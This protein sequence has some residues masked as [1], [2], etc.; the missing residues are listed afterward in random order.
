M[1][2]TT[3]T[4]DETSDPNEA[5]GPS[6]DETTEAQPSWEDTTDKYST[7]GQQALTAAEGLAQGYAGPVATAAELVASKLGVPGVS[8]EEISARQEA[9]PTI[10]TVSQIAGTGV[11]LL[12]GTGEAG[13]LAKGAEQVAPSF[14]GQIGGRIFSTGV[15]SGL[16]Q[17][18][19]EISK[20][21]LGQA[22][23]THPYAAAAADMGAAGLLG[24][25]GGAGAEAVE[26]GTAPLLKPVLE[27]FSNPGTKAISFLDGLRTAAGGSTLA[28]VAMDPEA[29]AAGSAVYNRFFVP[30]AAAALGAYEGSKE[31]NGVLDSAQKAIIKGAKYAAGA[32]ALQY[33]TPMILRAAESAPLQV[34]AGGAD[35]LMEYAKSIA[36]GSGKI[37][38]ALD[39]LFTAGTGPAIDISNK[40]QEG[41]R[42]KLDDYIQNGGID[43]T[44]LQMQSDQNSPAGFAEG[45]EVTLHGKPVKSFG[46]AVNDPIADHLPEQSLLL[47]QAKGRISNYLT[48]LR[49]Q[50]NMPKLAFDEPMENK[51]QKKSYEKA[52]DIA[53]NPLSILNHVK[54]GSLTPEHIQHFNAMYPEL[55]GH[56]QSKI[57]ERITEQQL[58]KKKPPYAVRQG[59]SLLLG[60]PLS[61]EVKPQNIMAAQSVFAQQNMA[62]QMQQQ[63]EQ[64]PNKKT[65]TLS[66]VSSQYMTG[67]QARIME[68]Q[69]T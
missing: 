17:G 49:P 13:L 33:F 22:D 55:T 8:A 2:D 11:G 20:G 69:K 54:D 9:N 30:S 29:Q 14:L 41:P 57:T 12:T 46:V 37:A 56:L 63:E 65:S 4:W 18:G 34:A 40:D 7:P 66:K 27:K 59:L 64:K 26:K 23:P 43:K 16:I 25:V 1:A 5:K 68:E 50:E 19:D 45:G 52:L 24:L 42:K 61:S 58:D 67:N 21:L 48:S 15:T 44:L 31:G 60:T 28:D 53:N 62:K 3:P 51:A 35:S 10:S 38:K 39:G 36:N 47:N 32:K 6:W